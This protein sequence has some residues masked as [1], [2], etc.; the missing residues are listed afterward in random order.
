LHVAA[1]GDKR[2]LL[3]PLAE[4]ICTRIDTKARAIWID[5]PEDLLDLNM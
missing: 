4:T 3:I 2:E 5:P 1:A